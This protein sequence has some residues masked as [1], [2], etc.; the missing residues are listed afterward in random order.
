MVPVFGRILAE[1]DSFRRGSATT[2]DP[3]KEY[4]RY[5]DAVL[6]CH[7]PDLKRLKE[8]RRMGAIRLRI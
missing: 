4:V 3:R 5:H 1:G 8:L 2:V 7:P 6:H